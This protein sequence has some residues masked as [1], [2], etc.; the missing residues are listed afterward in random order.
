MQ[1]LEE[2]VR[3]ESVERLSL[4]GAEAWGEVTVY[5]W[6]EERA[7]HSHYHA[8]TLAEAIA[9]AHKTHAAAPKAGGDGR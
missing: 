9:K 6:T 7:T 4:E 3:A 1:Q 2:L 8:G 5:Y